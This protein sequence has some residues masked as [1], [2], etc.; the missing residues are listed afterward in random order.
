MTC[1]DEEA[2][3]MRLVMAADSRA[4]RDFEQEDL[5]RKNAEMRLKLKNTPPA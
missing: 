1:T 3:R 4:R 5:R 2:G